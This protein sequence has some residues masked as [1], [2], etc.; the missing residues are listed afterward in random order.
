VEN[1]PLYKNAHPI[2]AD[3]PDAN[4]RRSRRWNRKTRTKYFAASGRLWRENGTARARFNANFTVNN[5]LTFR[6]LAA[7]ALC[8]ED[9]ETESTQV[10]PHRKRGVRPAIRRCHPSRVSIPLHVVSKADTV[11]SNR[12]SRRICVISSVSGKFPAISR[13]VVTDRREI[14]LKFLAENVCR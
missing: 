4:V 1:I 8:A 2:P 10:A 13:T 5:G 7:D 6:L 3:V 14:I 9:S 12:S 11:P